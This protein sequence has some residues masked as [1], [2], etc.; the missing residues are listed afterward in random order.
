MTE[1]QV[2]RVARAIE[3]PHLPVPATCKFSLDE[4]RETRWGMLSRQEQQVRLNEARAAIAAVGDEWR[5]IFRT[6]PDA[7]RLGAVLYH[8]RGWIRSRVA[9]WSAGGWW[10]N[11]ERLAP[12]LDRDSDYW[13]PLP[14]APDV[15]EKEKQQ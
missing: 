13:R 2:E 7:I 6:E 4:L 12:P 11:G 3:G 15:T 1:D 10:T 14:K 5:T 9:H 8:R